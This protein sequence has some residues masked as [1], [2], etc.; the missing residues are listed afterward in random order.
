MWRMMVRI[1]YLII[2]II[3][4]ITMLLSLLLLLHGARDR[5]TV[6]LPRIPI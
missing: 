1:L 2:C 3:Y 4:I 5:H 6:H